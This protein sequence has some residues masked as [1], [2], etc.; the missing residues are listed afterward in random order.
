MSDRYTSCQYVSD[1]RSRHEMK[2][3]RKL[4]EIDI[5]LSRTNALLQQILDKISEEKW[6]ESKDFLSTMKISIAVW[7]LI[8]VFKFFV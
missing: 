4:E 5:N 3:E 6:Y 8:L 1:D 2:I 7:F